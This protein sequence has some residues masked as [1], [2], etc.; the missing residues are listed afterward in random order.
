[1]GQE[2]GVER[3]K[4]AGVT[5]ETADQFKALERE[6]YD[7]RMKPC[8]RH[9]RISPK[10]S[11]SPPP[12]EEKTALIDES[13]KVYGDVPAI[14]DRADRVSFLELLLL[15]RDHRLHRAET[16]IQRAI[17][18]ISHLVGTTQSLIGRNRLRSLG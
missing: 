1:M 11:S 3:R 8:A 12:P 16:W 13:C 2:G 4:R 7:R 10:A 9:H 15:V 5:I 6:N 18:R 17:P 14:R